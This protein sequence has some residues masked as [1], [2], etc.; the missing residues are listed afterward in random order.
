[1]VTCHVAV[2][3]GAKNLHLLFWIC[4]STLHPTRIC[5]WREKK[6][7]ANWILK[8]RMKTTSSKTKPFWK[9][10]SFPEQHFQKASLHNNIY[11][12]AMKTG[13]WGMHLEQSLPTYDWREQEEITIRSSLTEEGG[14]VALPSTSDV[15]NEVIQEAHVDW[16]WFRVIFGGVLLMPC[17]WL[18]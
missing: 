15:L 4:F 17:L 1:M 10:I 8:K 7:K 12:V 6:K 14:K 11:R 13:C 2:P 16:T 9:G 5:Q 3:C 18:I